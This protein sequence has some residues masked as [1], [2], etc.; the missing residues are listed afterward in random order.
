MANKQA[1]SLTALGIGA[2][3]VLA[4]FTGGGSLLGIPPLLGARAFRG[5]MDAE[6]ERKNRKR[7]R[8]SNMNSLIPTSYYPPISRIHEPDLFIGSG[9]RDPRTALAE[10]DPYL[11]YRALE[12]EVQADIHRSNMVA[13]A[14]ALLEMVRNRPGTRRIRITRKTRRSLFFGKEDITIID[15][16]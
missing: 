5:A 6:K 12:R 15:I 13:S 10:S 4:P 8:S 9:T 11:G 1:D 3:F 14:P 7:E 2:M 16:R